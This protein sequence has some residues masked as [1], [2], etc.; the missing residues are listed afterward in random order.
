[1]E[2]ECSVVRS[3]WDFCDGKFK[4]CVE[5]CVSNEMVV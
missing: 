4:I 3:F 1:M 5:V 2:I